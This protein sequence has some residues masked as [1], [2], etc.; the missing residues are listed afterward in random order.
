M[1]CVGTLWLSLTCILQSAMG[2]IIRLSLLLML[3]SHG[4]AGS[5][6]TLSLLLMSLTAMIVYWQNYIQG[7][8]NNVGCC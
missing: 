3:P 7:V 6:C 8:I 1:L 4:G 2:Q 5:I